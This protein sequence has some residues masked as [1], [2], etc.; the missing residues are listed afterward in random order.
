MSPNQ[1][2]FQFDRVQESLARRGVGAA[3]PERGEVGEDGEQLRGGDC[4]LPAEAAVLV[5]PELVTLP[6][7]RGR[8]VTCGYSAA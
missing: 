6:L 5:Q 2:S 1:R 8:G 7:G 4:G 3:D